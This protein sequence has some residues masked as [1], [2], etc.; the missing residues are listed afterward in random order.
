MYVVLTPEIVSYL[1]AFVSGGLVKL[2]G[3]VSVLCNQSVLCTSMVLYNLSA[4]KK[5]SNF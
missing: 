1:L 4:E 2:A 3:L 5:R